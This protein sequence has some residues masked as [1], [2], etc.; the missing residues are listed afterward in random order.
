MDDPG[1]SGLDDPERPSRTAFVVLLAFMVVV[2]GVVVAGAGYYHWCKGAGASHARVT[3][4][5]AQGDTGDEVVQ[6]LAHQGVIRCGG[7]VGRVLLHNA[8]GAT[9]IRAGTYSLTTNMTLAE[10]IHV[11]TTPP[12]SVPT[13]RFTIPE[14]YRITDIADRAANLLK[15]PSGS[16]V[17]SAL[18]SGNYSL[19]QYLPAGTKSLEGFLFPDTYQI[20]KDGATSGDVIGKMLDQFKLEA[21]KLHLVDGAKALGYTPYQIVT[22]A[23]M[24]E[25]EA[26]VDRDRA[27]IAAV[28]YN[29]LK[30]NMTLGI[31]A[32]LLYDDP[33]PDGQLSASDLRSN[34][35][36]NTRIHKGLPPTP[37][38]NPGYKSLY[39][40]LHPAHVAYLYYVLCGKDGHHKF[41]ATY[42][43]FLHDKAAC[44]G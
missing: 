27:L 14:G 21:Q 10:A 37:I 33:T 1:R 17:E 31:D 13:V 15:I 34:S 40:A 7:V 41:S 28:I 12:T 8:G 6:Q 22:I 30:A 44:L 3:V 39:A 16:F 38:A 42:R 23:S 26:K 35:P 4:T 29:R 19:P 43:Q 24:I 25:R 36:Y 32:T 20:V 2:G 18:S 5:I 11:L 9:D